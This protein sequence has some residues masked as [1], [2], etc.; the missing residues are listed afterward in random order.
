M[1]THK[2]VLFL[3]NLLVVGLKTDLKIHVCSVTVHVLIIHMP[4]YIFVT[5]WFVW[6]SSVEYLG[7]MI[8]IPALCVNLVLGLGILMIDFS[9]EFRWLTS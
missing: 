1:N 9:T 4:F 7:F 5:A 8:S 2:F 3:T 6:I